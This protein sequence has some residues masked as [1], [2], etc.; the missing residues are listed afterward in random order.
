MKSRKQHR[1]PVTF[2]GVA[3]NREVKQE[4]ENFLEALRSYPDQFARQPYLSFEQHLYSITTANQH[5][6]FGE[7]HSEECN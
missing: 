3:R 7:E 4:I 6:G 5:C 2:T 1:I